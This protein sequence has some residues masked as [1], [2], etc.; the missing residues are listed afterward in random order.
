MA[1][2]VDTDVLID[3]SR[4]SGSAADFVDDLNGEVFIARISAMEL[5]IGARDRRDQDVIQKFISLF[6]L[7]E[8]S[9]VI[10]RDAYAQAK[11]YSKS[12]GLSLADAP[13]AATATTNDF[14]LVSR[15][16][17]HFGPIADLKFLRADY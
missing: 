1:F 13:I 6:Q 4:G 10:G 2:L 17:K 3:I 15:N 11:R 12:Y 7:A 14:T 16:E 5:I 8:L 9:D